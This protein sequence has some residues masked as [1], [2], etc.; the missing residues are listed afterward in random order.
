MWYAKSTHVIASVSGSV[1]RLRSKHCRMRFTS[2]RM[3]HLEVLHGRECLL[4]V[5]HQLQPVTPISRVCYTSR[6]STRFSPPHFYSRRL[7]TPLVLRRPFAS[8]PTPSRLRATSNPTFDEFDAQ[9][10]GVACTSPSGSIPFPSIHRQRFR[11]HGGR[12]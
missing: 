12:F 1:S 7:P 9:M 2:L 5:T 6:W 8:L 3:V 10:S 4:S 11:H